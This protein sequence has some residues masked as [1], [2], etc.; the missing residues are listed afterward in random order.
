MPGFIPLG[1]VCAEIYT[2]SNKGL[3]NTNSFDSLLAEFFI[4]MFI[5]TAIFGFVSDKFSRRSIFIY[6]MTGYCA[7]QFDIACLGSSALIGIARLFAGFAVGMQL[8]NNDS[9][10]TQLIPRAERGRYMIASFTFI[11]SAIPV[12]ALHCGNPSGSPERKSE[13]FDSR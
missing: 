7:A 5:S 2:I 6:S 8:I 10:I 4:G 12:A 11:L 1:L 9:Y 3:L 13:G